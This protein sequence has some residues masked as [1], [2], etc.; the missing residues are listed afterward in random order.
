MYDYTVINIKFGYRTCRK[1][2]TARVPGAAKNARVSA[3]C[4]AAT[5]LNMNGLSHGKAAGFCGDA[6]KNGGSRSWSYRNKIFAARR[7]EPEYD[8]TRREILDEPYLQCD[9]MWRNL[10]K[11]NGGRVMVAR[12]SRLCLA[13]VVWSASTGAVKKM[14]PGYGDTVGQD[15]NPIWMHTGG[16]RQ[17]CMQHRYH[18]S[19][20]DIKHT[21]PKGD[22]LEFLTALKRLDCKHHVYDRMGDPH[23]RMVAAKCLE[24]ER[25]G[26]LHGSH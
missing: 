23:T 5:A 16:D 21:N 13:V 15:S 4:S 9:E 19:K 22:I 26:L 20:K 2:Y 24:K 18:L 8:A 17:M 6:P 14:L 11:S 25:S 10:P 1:Q 7:L 12:G 3:N